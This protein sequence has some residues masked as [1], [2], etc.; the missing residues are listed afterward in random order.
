MLQRQM[1]LSKER[2]SSLLVTVLERKHE[3]FLPKRKKM[4]VILTLLVVQRRK[5][6]VGERS[7]AATVQAALALTAVN[8]FSV[9]TCP[10]LEAAAARSRHVRR[11]PVW[12]M[13]MARWRMKLLQKRA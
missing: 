8:A 13:R 7:D 12:R 6:R 4:W 3:E 10:G 2:G 5:E 11:E 9:S 1:G